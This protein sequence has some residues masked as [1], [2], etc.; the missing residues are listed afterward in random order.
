MKSIKI[1]TSLSVLKRL[2]YIIEYLQIRKARTMDPFHE[3]YALRGLKIGAVIDIQNPAGM[4]VREKIKV[5][6]VD[7]GVDSENSY[8]WQIKPWVAF[9]ILKKDGSDSMRPT[10]TMRGIP[11]DALMLASVS[12]ADE[13]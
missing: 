9:K 3:C 2:E 12:K 10:I 8:P 11:D 6:L 1:E 13:P 5:R 7:C 4:A